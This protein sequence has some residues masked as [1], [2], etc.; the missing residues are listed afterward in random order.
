MGARPW[1]PET[2]QGGWLDMRKLLTVLV[3]AG[4]LVALAI[5]G[6]GAL[7]SPSAKKAGHGFA[8]ASG[9]SAAVANAAAA[10]PDGAEH[11]V[12]IAKQVRGE[13]VDLGASGEST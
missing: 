13:F 10:A 2:H 11:I 8:R 1:A 3:A 9:G 6:A 12:L 5:V 4:A 7:A